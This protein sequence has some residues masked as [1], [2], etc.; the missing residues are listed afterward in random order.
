M[1]EE[2][3]WK[4]GPPDWMVLNTD[5]S[6]INRG[7]HAAAGGMLRDVHG[8]CHRAFTINLGACYIT[9]AEMQGV[10]VGLSQVWTLG[11]QRVLAVCNSQ[12][13]IDLFHQEGYITHNHQAE[14]LA[15]RELMKCNWEVE[16]RHSYREG[17][18]AADDLANQGLRAPLGLHLIHVSDSQLG[19][20]L[21]YDSLSLTEPRTILSN[22]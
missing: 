11:Y 3:G 14:V 8:R 19:H 1:L 21:L 4:P 7:R 17:N 5:D 18:H 6:V 10:L 9:R 22:S 2:I 15:F 16:I 13:V 20:F 12:A